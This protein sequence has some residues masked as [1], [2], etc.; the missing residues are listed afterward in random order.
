MVRVDWNMLM[1]V[2]LKGCSKKG[3]FVVKELKLGLMEEDMKENGRMAKCM[4]KENLF[5]GKENLIKESMSTM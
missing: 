4:D 5:G 2:F 3:C 1:V